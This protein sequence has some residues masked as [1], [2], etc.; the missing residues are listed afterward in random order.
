MQQMAALVAQSFFFIRNMGGK[1]L[2]QGIN[3][4]CS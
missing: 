1:L 3:I 4:Y 2:E